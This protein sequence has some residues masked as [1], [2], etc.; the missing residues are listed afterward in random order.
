MCSPLSVSFGLT[1]KLPS[2]FSCLCFFV[3]PSCE[4]VALVFIRRLHSALIESSR[5]QAKAI[6]SAWLKPLVRSFSIWL[7]TA[8]IKSG[9]ALELC[10][11][12]SLI[13]FAIGWARN[14]LFE[15]FRSDTSTLAG[16]SYFVAQ[17]DPTK[18]G[19]SFSHSIQRALLI[20]VIGSEQIAQ[21]E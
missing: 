11:R 8:H 6:S 1:T 15:N 4:S 9:F 19:R 14:R 10:R 17:V 2:K 7:G 5:P 3:K 20:L 16:N 12:F 13:I 21:A 18:L